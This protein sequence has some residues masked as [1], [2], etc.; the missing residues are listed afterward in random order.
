M[1]TTA[2]RPMPKGD[3]GYAETMPCEPQSAKRARSLVAT[4]LST[5]GIGDLLDAGTLI[6]DELVTN[7]IDH[8]RSRTV[9]VVIRRVTRDR[10]RIGVADTSREVPGAGMPDEDC[11]GGRGLVLVDALSDRW[12]YDLHPTWKLVWAE[13]RSHEPTACPEDLPSRTHP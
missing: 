4:A 11:E 9:R 8:T 12:G 5:W 1:I 3:P 6:V 13:L 7:A 10:V 2:T